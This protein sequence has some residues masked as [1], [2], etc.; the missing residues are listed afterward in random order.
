MNAETVIIIS[1]GSPSWFP[2]TCRLALGGD[3]YEFDMS[4]QLFSWMIIASFMVVQNC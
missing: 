4:M 1:A 2:V 3:T